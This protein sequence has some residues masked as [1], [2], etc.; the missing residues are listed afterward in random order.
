MASK[1]AHDRES[2]AVAVATKILR[3]EEAGGTRPELL[4][5][6]HRSLAFF[7]FIQYYLGIVCI[8]FVGVLLV[9]MYSVFWSSTPQD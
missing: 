1:R 2:H 6:D 7:H 4:A 3:E 5:A 9:S 8:L